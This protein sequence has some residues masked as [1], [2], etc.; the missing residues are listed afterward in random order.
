MLVEAVL[1]AVA[2]SFLFGGSFR[3]MSQVRLRCLPVLLIPVA[4]SLLTRLRL[5]LQVILTLGRPGAVGLALLRY[6]SLAAFALLNWREWT[7]GLI[8]LGGLC[9]GVVTLFNGGVMPVSRVV[10][11]AGRDAAST[12]LLEAGR[13]F[14]YRLAD[15][16]TRLPL[17]GDILRVRG[18][19]VYLLSAGD[20][21]I[22]CGL[23]ALV[24]RLMGARLPRRAARR[25]RRS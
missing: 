5:P 6:G 8:G 21:L 7:V 25:F 1:L 17:L 11:R 4:V 23:F 16:G 20:V 18:F 10:L 13:V 15:S 19:S 3:H 2:V 22:A 9:N 24:L 14:G 12:R